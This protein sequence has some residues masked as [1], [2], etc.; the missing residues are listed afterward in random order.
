MS[1]SDGNLIVSQNDTKMGSIIAFSC[2]EG[3]NLVGEAEIE[4][5]PSG[6]W[7]ADSPRCRGNYK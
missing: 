4:C 2:P 6:H 1:V 7:S 3:Q 5:L